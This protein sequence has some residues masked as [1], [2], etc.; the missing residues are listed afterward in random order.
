MPVRTE[1]VAALIGTWRVLLGDRGA[2]VWFDTSVDGFWRSFFAAAIAA[3]FYVLILALS[4]AGV[5][6][7]PPT[8]RLFAVHGLIYVIGWVLFPLIMVPVSDIVDR[9]DRYLGFIVVYNWSAILQYGF[10]AAVSLLLTGGL[11]TGAAA[12]TIGLV[13]L[14][15]IIA[16][17]WRITRIALDVPVLATAGVVF[18]EFFL[19]LV[20]SQITAVMLPL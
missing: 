17:V 20:V 16:Y 4:Y 3:P 13:S 1:I 8:A 11:V 7:L 14:L 2:L 6:P 12:Q 10:Y 5:D 19:S 18:L 15:I 9:H